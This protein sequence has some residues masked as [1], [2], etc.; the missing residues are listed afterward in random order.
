[1]HMVAG[2]GARLVLAGLAIGILGAVALGQFLSGQLFGVTPTD[3]LS[4]AAALVVVA[5]A[6]ALATWLPARRAVR[7]SPLTALQG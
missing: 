1:M 5:A 2:Q 7:V 4:L 3:G 6:A